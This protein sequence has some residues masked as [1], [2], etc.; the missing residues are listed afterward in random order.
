MPEDEGDA[1]MGADEDAADRHWDAVA[2]GWALPLE[3]TA[4]Q[5][6][7]HL[8]VP[9]D[10]DGPDL[11]GA[12]LLLLDH[13]L[14]SNDPSEVLPGPMPSLCAAALPVSWSMHAAGLAC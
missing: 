12:E 14:F 2:A 10:S 8:S 9:D 6:T 7:L 1:F 3:E 13:L 5:Q 4:V 11:S